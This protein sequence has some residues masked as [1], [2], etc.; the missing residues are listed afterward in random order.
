MRKGILRRYIKRE[1]GATIIEYAIV[2]PILF[3]MVMGIIEF[4]LLMYA[5]S[6]LDSAT[7]QSARFGTTNSDYVDEYVNPDEIGGRSPFIISN[8]ERRAVKSALLD[9][10]KLSIDTSTFGQCGNST[11]YNVSYR[12][13]FFTP[14]IGEFF[15]SAQCGSAGVAGDVGAYNICSSAFVTNEECD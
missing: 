9:K 7:T 11:L 4:S 2:A 15:T 10:D 14:F 1:E 6:V 3:L 5:Q 12:W 13:E 8:I